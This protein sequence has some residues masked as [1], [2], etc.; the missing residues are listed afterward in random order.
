M[1]SI[2]GSALRVLGHLTADQRKGYLQ[3]VE[4]LHR[5]LSHHQQVEVYRARLKVRVTGKGK[6]LPQ[7]AHEETLVSREYPT[8]PKDMSGLLVSY[9][10]VNALQEKDL[11]LYMKQAH[12]GD[13]Q[14]ALTKALELEAF[15]HTSMGGGA[16]ED[17]Q[18]TAQAQVFQTWRAQ[19]KRMPGPPGRTSP[20]ISGASAEAVA[21]KDTREARVQ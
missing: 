17:P 8:A 10:F 14:E 2:R 3:V 9:H 15:L 11:Q 12:S 20:L 6:T 1:S 16:T 5:M 7:L 18:G 21:S 19:A 13:L 4:S